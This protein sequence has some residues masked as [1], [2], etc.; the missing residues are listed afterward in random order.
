[1][2]IYRVQ[3]TFKW[4]YMEW[5][6]PLNAAAD[7][8]TRTKW[9]APRARSSAGAWT[10]R[11]ST[12]SCATAGAGARAGPRTKEG[13]LVVRAGR[14]AEWTR[15]PLLIASV[16]S[17]QFSSVRDQRRELRF[18]G[19]D[20]FFRV[21]LGTNVMNIE[22]SGPGNGCNWAVPPAPATPVYSVRCSV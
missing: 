12:G 22:A 10:A 20:G 19:E 5:R 1:M 17:Q 7:S 21:A 13:P 8:C 2:T 14:K 3:I 11:R 4:Q 18:W 6:L 16:R 9:A 15:T